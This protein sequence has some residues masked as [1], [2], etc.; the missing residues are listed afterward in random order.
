[1]EGRSLALPWSE[2]GLSGLL[3]KRRP[4]A[5]F[6]SELLSEHWLRARFE[7]EWLSERGFE[8]EWLSVRA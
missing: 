2:S 6:E 3:S 5:R 7:S 1:M 4:R 8:S